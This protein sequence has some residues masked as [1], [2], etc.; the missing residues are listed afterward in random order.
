MAT[1]DG[2]GSSSFSSAEDAHHGTESDGSDELV[3]PKDSSQAPPR[4]MKMP[5]ESSVPASIPMEQI[6]KQYSVRSED[7]RHPYDWLGDGAED[8]IIS[9]GKRSKQR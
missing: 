7:R 3:L 2:Q 9:A 5:M 8:V 1:V 4:P 6:R